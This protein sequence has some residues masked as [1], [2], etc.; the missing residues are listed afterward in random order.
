M[1]NTAVA[2]EG[3]VSRTNCRLCSYLC[4]LEAVIRNGRIAE[5][6]P[7]P[8]RYPYDGSIVKGCRRF[9]SNLEFLNHPERINY[10]LKRAGARG[11]G[12]WEQVSWEDALDDIAERLTALKKAYGAETLATSIGGPHTT[13]WPLHR[14]MN[15]FGSPNNLG[16][17]QICWNP[18]IWVNSLTF[19]WPL[20]NEIAPEATEC[21][22]L[23][24]GNPAESDNSL[25]WRNIVEYSRS[26]QPLIVID[27][28]RTRTAMLATRWLAPRPGSDAALALGLLHVII[29]E[30]LYDRNFV[31]EYCH[32][33][34]ELRAQV[35]S[36]TPQTVA[37][38]T[39]LKLDDIVLTARQYASARPGSIFH[40]RGIDQIGA[41][42]FQVHRA[43][44]AL[45]GITGNV[46]VPGANQV[47]EMPDF[48]AE[49]DLE[50]TDRLSPQQRNKQLGK[51]QLVLQTYQAYE[52]LTR[53]TSKHGKRLPARYLTSAQ[54]DL[55][56]RAML[57]GVPYPVRAMVVSGS[58]PLLCQAD[59]KQIFAAL[60]SLDLLVCLELFANPVTSLADY[61]LPMAGSLERPVL[62]TNAGV[63]NFAYG[64]PA[65]IPPL[66]ERRTDF[67]FWRDLGIRCG[68]N[69]E[70]P[71]R[72]FSACLDE[73]VA[74]LGIDWQQFCANGLYAP[75]PSYRK[76]REQTPAFATPSGKV[77]L[78]SE[79]LQQLGGEPLP[80]HKGTAATSSDYPL[81][82]IS[83]GRKQPYWASSFRQLR[84]LHKDRQRPEAEINRET[85]R[86]LGLEN[87][88]Q[89]W[90][91]TATGRARFY[92][93]ITTMAVAVVNVDYG[94]WFPQQD[95][96]GE[97]PGGLFD[98]NVNLLTSADFSKSDPL[99]GQWKYNDIPCRIVVVQD[100]EDLQDAELETLR[101]SDQC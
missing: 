42:S 65:A 16:I 84:R 40:G 69:R 2:S 23:W 50:L 46:D 91:E 62:Q 70:W 96:A 53:H 86:Q 64:G 63:S 54:P 55:I 13:F 33:F 94:W 93:K 58:N 10:P 36:Y 45:K 5:L 83:G 8:S 21:L 98:A 4:G 99:L 75:P 97:N 29:R 57:E 20:E 7:D 47:G 90:V 1:K 87:G 44:A 72:N 3:R 88:Q 38:L 22:L 9:H 51:D 89:V 100:N 35:A 27:P 79:L 39:G 85:A 32:G 67:A 41:N 74:P 78:Y 52:E 31:A 66:F 6:R 68:Q 19:G 82:M 80:Q 12:K 76:Y 81:T 37:E 11:S 73:I 92:I 61:I 17:G 101:V 59:S 48:T 26:C 71:W 28:R 14:F 60:G 77:E 34:T 49:I 56:W 43:I 30:E 15:L 18:A 95:L 25:F 24:G